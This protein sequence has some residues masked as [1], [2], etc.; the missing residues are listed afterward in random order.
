MNFTNNFFKVHDIS[1]VFNNDH[2]KDYP[3]EVK[4]NGKIK[5]HDIS[6]VFNEKKDSDL[7]MKNNDKIIEEYK[8]DK[9]SKKKVHN[10][11][12][13]ENK[14]K[15][16]KSLNDNQVNVDT[17]SLSADLEKIKIE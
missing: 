11:K 12:E 1:F 7:K 10:R 3:L 15:I 16:I 14:K 13:I 2:K 4:N 6:F 9:I 8:K 5:T 17:N